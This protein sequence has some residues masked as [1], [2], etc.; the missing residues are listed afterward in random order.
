M[1]MGKPMAASATT[2][3]MVQSG[4]PIRGKAMSAACITAKA[5]AP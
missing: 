2:N 5:T 3:V 4:S 1:A